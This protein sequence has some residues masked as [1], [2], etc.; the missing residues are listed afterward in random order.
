MSALAWNY[1]GLG[2]YRAVRKVVDIVQAQGP[3][4]MFLSETWFDKEYMEKVCYDLEFD[5][6]FAVPNNGRGG[7]LAMLWKFEI[8][9]WVD[10]FSNY[11]IDVIVN[12]GME[13]AAVSIFD[14][15]VSRGLGSL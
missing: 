6:L 13:D 5:G 10:S 2:T 7:G 3:K 12:G 1:K 8:V 11:H 14:A 15:N 4:I 9:V